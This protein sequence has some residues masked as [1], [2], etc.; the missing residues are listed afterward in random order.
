MLTNR[1]RRSIHDFIADTIV[2]RT[3]TEK[4]VDEE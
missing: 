3:N 4:A 2:I 1:R